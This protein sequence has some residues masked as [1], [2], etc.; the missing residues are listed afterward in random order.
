MSESD[1]TSP[2][3]L[4]PTSKV[5][6]LM[7]AFDD[8]SDTESISAGPARARIAANLAKL[9]PPKASTS[10]ESKSE[11]LQQKATQ[12]ASESASEDEEDVIVRPKGRVAARMQANSDSTDEGREPSARHARERVS[13]MLLTKSKSPTPNA[14]AE[15][16]HSSSESDVPVVSRKRKLRVARDNAHIDDTSKSSPARRSASPG[17]FVSPSKPVT[18]DTQAAGSDSDVDL[19]ATGSARFNALV[20]KKRQ[21]RL[22]KEAEAAKEKARHAEERRRNAEATEGDGLDDS[23][24]D[25][26][27][28]QSSRPAR[29]ASKKAL[30]EMHRETQRLSRNMQLA[31][32][33]TTKKKFTKADFFAKFNQGIT[34]GEN[35]EP[36]R[37]TSSSSAAPHSDYEHKD[38]PPS[39]PTSPAGPGE[40]SG[41]PANR[42][43]TTESRDNEVV[44]L[45][46]S[47]EAMTIPSSP[48]TRLDKGKGK[49]IEEPTPEIT[50][51][52]ELIKKPLF[53]QRPIRVRVPKVHDRKASPLD[54]S[55]SDLEIVSVK[56]IGRKQ[57]LDSI[58][59]RVPAKLAKEPHSLH[60]LRMLA[61]VKSPGK[62][63]TSE[64]KFG[65]RT[66]LSM[67]TSELQMSLQQRAR[68]Q[69]TRDREERIKALRDKGVVIQTAEERAK[70]L[71]EVEDIVAKARLEGEAIAKR[72][73]AQAKKER[74]K[75]GEADPLGDHSSD[76]EDY[77][78]VQGVPEEEVSGSGSGSGSSEGESEVEEASANGSDEEED[79]EMVLGGQGSK[80]EVTNS[81]FDTHAAESETEKF[82]VESDLAMHK[83]VSDVIGEEDEDEELPP[84]P[85]TRRFRNANVIS[86][87]EDEVV[88]EEEMQQTPVVPQVSPLQLST[89][90]PAEPS[91]VLRSA[92]KT[93]I[94]GVTV[95]GPA[96]LGLT[97]IFAGTMDDSQAFGTSATAPRSESQAVVPNQNNLDFLR[98]L[99]GAEL[100]PFVPTLEE[101]TQD[102]DTTNASQLTYIPN[103]QP[104]ET[105]TQGDETQ[106]QLDFSQ[107]QIHG[108]DSILQGTQMSQFP[109]TQ[110]V[111]YQRMT[112]IKGRF[113]DAPP[114]TVDTVLLEP[115]D[116]PETMDETPVVK[117][118][119]K[120]RQR[121]HVPTFSDDEDVEQ[122]SEQTAE[123]ED[124]DITADVFDVMRKA[125]TKATKKVVDEFDKKK[126][127]AKEMVNEQADESDDE[128][129]GLGG[130]SD[131]E[132]DGEADEFVKEMIDD[133]GGKHF[134]E[135]K[136]AAFFA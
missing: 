64:R 108:F 136:L 74:Q 67:T 115:N 8:D 60:A 94:P 86:D 37:P 30:E 77:E 61:G 113:V 127:K 3:P 59:D 102:A 97:Q 88:E 121:V 10:T 135:S 120:L 13:N 62:Q 6:A 33:A 100:P 87:D 71:A 125:A 82:D 90:S 40:K 25:R 91:S 43:R 20:A 122:P 58:F 18:S 92:T 53:T 24:G 106:I 110:D 32:K 104:V 72:E 79:E 65:R 112:P 17:L 9:S 75:T 99:K 35:L 116:L 109:P 134:D 34:K 42:P 130:A 29:K 123:E 28:T 15:E 95:A 128:Y 45:P 103:S 19:P 41:A 63:H 114:S 11:E 76:D 78:E 81:M 16:T 105:E 44:E 46:T 50:M 2:A 68:Q 49:A 83:D 51:E 96:G 107:S 118:K 23:E 70:D 47:E 133:E 66:K 80:T 7:A 132:S 38:T 1:A 12:K 14:Q 119:G 129:A 54:D 93:F 31:H 36:T 48:P 5:K 124:L 84:K 4:T 26:R 101:D 69:A 98:R 57:Q 73:K 39:S 117:R 21:E 131:D 52:A 27:L 55:D 89:N 111:G 85:N 22:A 56:T 126:S